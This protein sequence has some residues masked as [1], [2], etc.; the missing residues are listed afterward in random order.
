MPILT[1]ILAFVFIVFAYIFY[2]YNRLAQ[3]HNTLETEWSLVD[4]LLKKRADLIPNIIET[5]KGYAKHEKEVLEA[6][7]R[8]RA[9]AVQSKR[10]GE[11]EETLSSHVKS[12][13]ALREAYPDLKA[14]Q[15]FMQ[16]QSE[17]FEIEDEIAE[18]RSHFNNV[19]KAYN[20]VVLGFP[21]NVVAR[22]IGFDLEDYFEFLGSR[23]AP[24]L[25]LFPGEDN[26]T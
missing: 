16:L 17:L 24:K 11:G 2:V 14:N 12:I 5:V 23:E 10:K 25:N 3:L 18:E 15:D 7:S 13:L 4:V 26:V 9:D 20:D 1:G 6:A 21:G 22:M 19:V 8:V